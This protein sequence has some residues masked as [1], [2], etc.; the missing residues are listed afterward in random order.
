M[1]F[2]KK[3]FVCCVRNADSPLR[4]LALCIV[5]CIVYQKL[6]VY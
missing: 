6:I 1:D 4:E 3:E 5:L 2:K